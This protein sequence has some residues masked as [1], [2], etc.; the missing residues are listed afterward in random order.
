MLGYNFQNFYEMVEHNAKENPKKM[1]LFIDK[2]KTSNIE[3][4][5]KIDILAD[6]LYEFGIRAGDAAAIIVANS[7]EFIVS[8]LAL[9]KLG[10][11]S[12]PINTFLK[13]EE[14]EHILNDCGA[15]LLFSSAA[16]AKETKKLLNSTKI[17]AIIWTEGYEYYDDKNLNYKTIMSRQKS[18]YSLTK[19]PAID[20]I[21]CIVYT[22]GT[23]GKPKG[24]MLSY[25]NMLSNM[26]AA[27]IAFRIEANDR[28]IVYLPMFHTFT[29]T[30]MVLLPIY[31]ASSVVVI[32]S[33]FPFSNILKQTLLKRVT[34]FLGVPTVYNAL[35]KAKI[36]WYFM[37]FHR[38][39]LYISG[40]APLSEKSLSDFSKKFTRGILL[41]GYGLSECSP[42]VAVN[43]LEKQKPLSVGPALPGYE[44]KIVDDEMMEL[45]TGEVGEII[46]KGDC[47][48]RGYLNRPE[49]TAETLIN[50]WVRTGD[51][52]KLDEEGFLF[53]VDRKKDLIISKGINIYPREIEEI[54]YQ[55]SDIETAAVIGKK[56]E[57]GD[58]D[59]VAFVQFKDGV[60]EPMSELQIKK[61]LKQHLANFKIPKHI[62][63][64]KELPKNATGKV[65]KRV[66]KEQLAG[67]DIKHADESEIF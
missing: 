16:Y 55:L 45:P 19:F 7:E 25:R 56:S 66:L 42:A 65:L 64:A 50:G 61:Y 36:P 39:R 49:A 11:V 6:F 31:F 2:Q 9:S 54:L 30:I 41:E 44:I 57:L 12:V 60:N 43:R 5:Q 13:R 51:L 34:I 47:A 29:L 59:V 67:M 52:G 38:V 8:L 32:K 3:L 62:F 27:K 18:V 21:A 37:W 28:F 10:A 40:S 33:V 15:K 63:F 35:I 46:V 17:E 1:L 48:M 24:A 4:K 26:V 23:T 58:E 53:I 22:S 20:D 14:F